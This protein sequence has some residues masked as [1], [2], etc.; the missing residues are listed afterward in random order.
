MT[1]S[2]KRL[3]RIIKEEMR[4]HLK[5]GDEVSGKKVSPSSHLTVSGEDIYRKA[6]KEFTVAI[7]EKKKELEAKY[8]GKYV[9]QRRELEAYKAARENLLKP[10]PSKA[11][12]FFLRKLSAIEVDSIVHRQAVW[13]GFDD[14][15]YGDWE[16]TDEDMYPTI[17]GWYLRAKQARSGR[18]GQDAGYD[19]GDQGYRRS[20]FLAAGRAEADAIVI[21]P[22]DYDMTDED[23]EKTK[24]DL[25]NQRKA[26]RGTQQ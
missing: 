26:R 15:G 19:S 24:T 8:L 6:W 23:V 3:K 14:Q 25:I 10:R 13:A 17:F 22:K 5:E 1:L 4:K 9:V 11:H 18:R 7:E 20:I 16:I 2:R 21:N 12:R